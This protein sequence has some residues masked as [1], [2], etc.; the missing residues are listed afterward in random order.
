MFRINQLHIHM[1]A[2]FR[3][4]STLEEPLNMKIRWMTRNTITTFVES[5]MYFYII[6]ENVLIFF[7]YLNVKLFFT[8]TYNA[9]PK[10]LPPGFSKFRKKIHI[11]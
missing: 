3:F 9:T 4:R 1:A 7:N 10:I 11:E 2:T 5:D 6:Y 8:I